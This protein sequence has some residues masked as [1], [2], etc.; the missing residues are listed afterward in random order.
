VAGAAARLQACRQALLARDLAAMGPV[1]E[2]DAILMHAVMMTSHPPLYYWQAATLALIQATQQWRAEGLPVYFTIDAGPNLHLL[3]EVAH[4]AAVE[5]AARQIP[6]VK[7][8]LS[9]GP[10]GPARLMAA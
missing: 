5:A 3:C 2:E 1:I 7:E 9:S 4:A 10:G 6:G 8:I